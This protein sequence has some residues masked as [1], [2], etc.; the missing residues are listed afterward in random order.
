MFLGHKPKSIAGLH[1]TATAND[2]R[3]DEPLAK[4]AELYG[5]DKLDAVVAI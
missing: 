5:V 4:L 1:Y 2:Y 3:L